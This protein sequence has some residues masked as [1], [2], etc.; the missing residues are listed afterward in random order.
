MGSIVGINFS[1][2]HTL[3]QV[4]QSWYRRR[5]SF[6]V[7]KENFSST[8]VSRFKTKNLYSILYRGIRAL[9]LRSYRA[10]LITLDLALFSL[11]GITPNQF[12]IVNGIVFCSVSSLD[13]IFWSILSAEEQSGNWGSRN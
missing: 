13:F 8:C 9:E 2:G 6:E 5:L 10:F 3:S 1:L 12:G 11:S 7:L 4:L